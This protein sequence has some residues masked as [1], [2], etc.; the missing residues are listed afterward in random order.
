[1]RERQPRT[2]VS[3]EPD[4]RERGE[5]RPVRGHL[6][7]RG[8]RG[9]RP[10]AVVRAERVDPERA[11]PRTRLAGGDAAERD[12][13]AVEAHERDDRQARH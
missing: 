12:G 13:V 2:A 8:E 1:V 11:Q 4:V 9:R 6:L 10:A 5:R 3:R 7:E